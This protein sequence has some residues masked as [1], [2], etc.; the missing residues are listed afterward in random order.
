MVV[1]EVVVP[2]EIFDIV[3]VNY[4]DEEFRVIA[5]PLGR[6]AILVDAE[7]FVR[8]LA[9]PGRLYLYDRAS[10]ILASACSATDQGS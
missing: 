7:L 2:D 10:V 9:R 6:I 1:V 8:R 3:S 5:S 4:L